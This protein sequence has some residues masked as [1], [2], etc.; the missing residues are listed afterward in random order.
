MK[1]KD[2]NTGSH[3]SK[4]GSGLLFP[5]PFTILSLISQERG[6]MEEV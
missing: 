5:H 4:T 1:I 2:L 6:N 3:D